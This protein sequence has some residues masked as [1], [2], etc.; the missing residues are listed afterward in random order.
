[1]LNE[2]I[3]YVDNFWFFVHVI[4]VD[5]F[6]YDKY[7][8]IDIDLVDHQIDINDDNDLL[9]KN[10]RFIFK[11]M[12]ISIYFEHYQLFQNDMDIVHIGLL[13]MNHF[14]RFYKVHNLL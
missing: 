9:Q 11:K 7:K 6:Q 1:M 8:K 4:Q 14:E 3:I 10:K 12:I 13:L 2:Q 5:H